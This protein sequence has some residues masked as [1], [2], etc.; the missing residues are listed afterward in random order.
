METG[1]ASPVPALGNNLANFLAARLSGS[2]GN[3]N[4]A[5]FG[6]TNPV[7]LT[8]DGNGVATGATFNGRAA[9]RQGHR[10]HHGRQRRQCRWRR[11]QP[12][13]LHAGQARTRVAR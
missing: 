3:L 1:T 12:G 13:Q 4:C 11:A 7:T 2:F 5:N 10:D 6:L 9:D 8:L